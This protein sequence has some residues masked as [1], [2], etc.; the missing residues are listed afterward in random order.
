ME[1]RIPRLSPPKRNTAEITA[2]SATFPRSGT[3]KRNTAM[4]TVIAISRY[5]IRKYGMSLPRTSSGGFTGVAMSCSMVPRSHSRATVSDVRRAAITTMITAMRPGM[6]KFLDLS[7]G[8]YQ[9]LTRGSMA[10]AALPPFNCREYRSVSAVR[11]PR[12]MV[13]VLESL[14]STMICSCA[15]RPARRSREKSAGMDSATRALPLSR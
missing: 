8:L 12:A 11:Y 3:S 4:T 5:P 1:I 7:S 2:S 6:M 15:A 10:G 13:A 14:P 9:T